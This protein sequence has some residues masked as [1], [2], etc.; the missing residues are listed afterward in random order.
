MLVLQARLG[1]VDDALAERPHPIEPGALALRVVVTA[2]QQ[3][4]LDA[5][6]EITR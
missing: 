2:K 1:S 4:R 3:Q 6:V 5:F